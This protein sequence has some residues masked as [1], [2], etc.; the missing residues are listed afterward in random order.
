MKPNEIADL[1]EILINSQVI[2]LKKLGYEQKHAHQELLELTIEV[3]EKFWNPSDDD[4]LYDIVE[5]IQKR[6]NLPSHYP[7]Q[8]ISGFANHIAFK[9]IQRNAQLQIHHGKIIDQLKSKV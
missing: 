6:H 7:L 8:V 1:I 5:A 4:D 3:L 2:L 9:G